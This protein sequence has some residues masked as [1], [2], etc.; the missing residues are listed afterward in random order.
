MPFGSRAKATFFSLRELKCS[1][2][3]S[4]CIST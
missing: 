4:K 3:F 2:M 1:C